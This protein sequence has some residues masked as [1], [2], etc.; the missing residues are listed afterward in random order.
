MKRKCDFAEVVLLE[1]T[2]S[3]VGYQHLLKIFGPE[4][5]SSI[6]LRNFD[7]HLTIVPYTVS[8]TALLNQA[9]TWVGRIG[10]GEHILQNLSR[11]SPPPLPAATFSL[12]IAHMSKHCK[13][14]KKS[15]SKF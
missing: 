3:S 9:A 5:G 6:F 2:S 1:V 12:Y 10:R 14:K 8:R 13:M 15:V 4:D 11:A 7:I